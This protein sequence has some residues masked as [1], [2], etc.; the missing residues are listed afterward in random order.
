MAQLHII[1]GADAAPTHPVIRRIAVSDLKEALRRGIDDFSS[2]PSYAIFVGL[3][4]PIVGII[5]ARM[6]FGYAVLPLLFPLAAGFALVG[7][8]AATGLY[9]LSRR[10]EQG[11]DIHWTHAF[12][13][14]TK[15]NSGAIAALGILLMLIFL[16]WLAVAQALY[17]SLYGV[18]APE[19]ITQFLRDVLTTG[20]GWT[21]ILLGNAIGFLFAL[22]VLAISV[23]SFP[24]LVDRDVGAAVAVITSVR[25]VATNPVV[26]AVWGL[27]VAAL[28]VVGTVPAFFGLAI[29]VPILG[30]ATWHLYRRLVQF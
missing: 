1:A 8:F 24:L 7:P 9:E 26:I 25:A 14:T 23:V 28:L 10:R 21:L 12:D 6:T 16:S 22:L 3:I 30:H 18:L 27:I 5:L 20:T 13:M 29:V 17:Q 2:I 4:Y 19:S 11:L 15:P